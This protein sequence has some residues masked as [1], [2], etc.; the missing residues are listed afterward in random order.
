MRNQI[1]ERKQSNQLDQH[2]HFNTDRVMEDRRI[3]ED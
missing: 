2:Q 1:N 3:G